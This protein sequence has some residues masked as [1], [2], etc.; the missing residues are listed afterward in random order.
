ME[1]FTY[2]V[3]VHKTT[4]NFGLIQEIGDDEFYVSETTGLIDYYP[5]GT[6]IKKLEKEWSV[7]LS[8][9]EL[10]VLEIWK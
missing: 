3:L 8:N 10:R 9:Y 2:T 7:D 6:T 5:E 4:K 1:R